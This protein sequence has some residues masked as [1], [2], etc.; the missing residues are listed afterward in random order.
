MDFIQT[1]M[2]ALFRSG[3]QPIALG[4]LGL[5][6]LWTIVSTAIAWARLRHV[7]GPFLASI[8]YIW[9]LRAMNSGRIHHIIQD[10]QKK[11]GQVMRIGPDAVCIYDPEPLWRMNSAR[12]SYTRGLWYKAIRFDY[13]GDTIFTELDTATHDR[14]KA[15]LAAGY[16][17][18]GLLSLEVRVDAGIAELVRH[19]REKIARGDYKMDLGRLLQFFQVDLITK[20]G[21]DLSWGDLADETDHYK[22]LETT[23][24]TI[25]FAHTI[26]WSPVTIAIFSSSLFLRLFAPK[27]TDKEG[28]GQ[29][30]R[31]LQDRV[32]D[33]LRSGMH[34]EGKGD[35]ML[36]EW[37]KHGLSAE[38]CQTDMSLQVP[39]GTETSISTIRGI[40]LLLLT[41]PPVYAR[42]KQEIAAA[43]SAGQISDPMTNEEA[44]ALPYMQAIV[45][46]GLRIMPP[47]TVGFPKRVPAGGDTICGVFLPAGTDVHQNYI[48]MLKNPAVFGPD[49]DL[50][51]PERLLA[52]DDPAAVAHMKKTIDLTFGYGRFGCLGKVLAQ[53]EMNKIFVELLRNFDFQLVNPEK[54]WTR[55][56]YSTYMI[57]GFHAVVTE[58]KVA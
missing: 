26:A 54:A 30:L 21:M 43:I 4:V 56:S 20:A 13:R 17:G 2:D 14:R 27:L 15:K 9:G 12:S 31:I 10:E 11:Y 57:D 49:A 47:V 37:L 33:R 16:A 45:L 50:F 25:A 24:K 48:T 51:R 46:E 36:D 8:S 28:M 38:E 52:T 40:M 53:M 5:A 1:R 23:D 19:I 6:V 3:L 22:Y 41:S 42:A 55:K 58:G 7:P 29:F 44:K 34:K 18:R 32:Q 35:T 39:A